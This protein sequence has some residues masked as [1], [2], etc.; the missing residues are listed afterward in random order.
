MGILTDTEKAAAAGEV[1]SLII[2]SGQSATLLRKQTGE[3]L[4]G[5]DEGAF[6]DVG[7]F[8]LEF[9]ETP[10]ADIAQK[11]D[12]VASV[13]PELDVRVEDR[14]RFEGREFR[15]QAVAPQ[16]LFG[17]VTHKVLELVMLHDP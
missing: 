14:V 11:A 3:N 4:Y 1:R 15:V 6:A 13:L 12:A 5:T 9:S 2:A 8:A 10:P 7:T 17:V 16:S